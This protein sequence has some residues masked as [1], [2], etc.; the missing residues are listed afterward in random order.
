[1]VNNELIKHLLVNRFLTSFLQAYV[2]RS[3]T[4]CA[5]FLENSGPRDVTIQFLNIPYQLPRKSI[6]ILPG[7]KNVAFNTGKVKK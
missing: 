3:S 2:F 6:S 1:M 4:E 7:C 5:A